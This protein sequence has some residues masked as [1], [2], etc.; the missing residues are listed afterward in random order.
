MN[1]W[2]YLLLLVLILITLIVLDFGFGYLG[3]FK[4]KTI[5]KAQQNAQR[6][7][8]EQTQSY[9]ESKRQC[10]VKYYKEYVKLPDSSKAGLRAIVAHDFANFDEDKY[11]NGEILRFIKL[12]KYN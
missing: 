8:F 7:V 10:A 3:V 6:E 2:K 4:T 5:G 1:I 9:V 11:L 12:C